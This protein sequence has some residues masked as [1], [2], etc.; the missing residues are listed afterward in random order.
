MPRI[1][2]RTG[3]A[4]KTRL[5]S[6]KSV[7]KDNIVLEV[8]GS[9]DE[10][11][12]WLGLV[13]GLLMKS[14]LTRKRKIWFSQFLQTIQNDLFALGCQIASHQDKKHRNMPHICQDHIKAIENMI[15]S[16]EEELPPLKQ[17]I[18]PGGPPAIA[19]IHLARSICRRTERS[20]VSFIRKNPSADT[21][22][23]QY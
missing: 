22:T 21:I 12:S 4:G 11:N 3:D 9:I 16:L 18:L 8:C 10:L 14:T 7:W 1:Y 23:I 15:D 20:L 2:T 6:G 17:F 19:S 13:T 5:I